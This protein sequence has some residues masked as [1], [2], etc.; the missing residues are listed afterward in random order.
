MDIERYELSTN[1]I[2]EIV[3]EELLSEPYLEY[4]QKT[5]AFLVGLVKIYELKSK[6]E[7]CKLTT[8]EAAGLNRELYE[9]IIGGNYE[10]SYA[11][12]EYCF[13][14]SSDNGCNPKVWSYL[15]FIYAEL[16]ALIPY[17]YEGRADILVPFFELFI[18]VY[19]I[20]MNFP[21]DAALE[22]ELKEAIYWFER[23][24]LDFLVRDEVTRKLDPDRDFAVRIIKEADLLDTR[25][26]YEYGEY[27]SS[28]ELRISEYLSSLDEE[29]IRSMAGTIVEGYRA[30]FIKAGKPLDKKIAVDI[31]YSL[32]FERVVREV[33][34]M[35][36]EMGLKAVIYRSGTF[37]CERKK[38]GRAGSG[39][40]GGT[41]NRQYEYDHREDKALY[42]DREYV[43]RRLDIMRSVYEENKKLARGQAGPALI[44]T[45]GEE[46]FLPQSSEHA[47]RFSGV[48]SRLFVSY[49]ERLGKLVNDYIPMEE[50]GFTIISYPIPEIGSDFEEIFKETVRINTLD[51]SL[52]ESIQ[53]KI[54]DTLDKAERVH[55]VGRG[56]NKT[57]IN[58]ELHKLRDPERETNF[59]NSVA[60]VNIPL[61]E[62]FTSPVLEGTD[63]LLN[64]DGVY[65]E[66]LKYKNLRL[67]FKDG[68]VERY[69][70]E[71]FEDK[72]ENRHFIEE[73]LLFRN[74][75]LP[76]GEFAIGT[77]TAAYR[78]AGKYDIGA[79]LPILI[80]E[81]TGPHFAIGDTC[82]SREEDAKTYNPDGK[83]IIAKG[84]SYT[85]CEPDK[86]TYFSCHTDITIPYD[87]LGGIYAVTGTG[88]LIPVIENCLFVLEGTE[89]LNRYLE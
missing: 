39:F 43:R 72:E 20:F 11:N 68:R 53:Q 73:N 84:N 59:E 12:P 31:R 10:K 67:W 70:C 46:P 42:F 64:V 37:S 74:K 16:R 88:E 26:L 5:S 75:T 49:N 82:Y 29:D 17:A 57:D 77:N 19:C 14:I 9:D 24:S 32:G 30:G 52:Y 33:V 65:L 21:S 61:G 50:R 69:D 54:I 78:M 18:E 83:E 51:S 55:V 89:E 66:G 23:D 13:G 35:F 4:F 27:I 71:N 45:F 81:K 15:C 7:L 48:G 28:N 8:E 34:G 2:G 38:S 56:K 85:E 58:I 22:E 47:I 6:N 62:V 3:N 44:E 86:R 87:E 36:E 76:M 40:I 41:A 79:R 1:R 63:G 60:D 25:Y 80:G